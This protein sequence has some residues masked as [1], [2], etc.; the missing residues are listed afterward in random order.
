MA[1]TDS[2]NL[3]DDVELARGTNPTNPDTDNDGLLDGN[4]VWSQTW[5]I[6]NSPKIVDRSTISSSISL[7]SFTSSTLK[8]I[9]GLTL[10]LGIAHTYIGD[11]Y[12]TISHGGK[13]A[14]LWNRQGGSADYIY[15][16]YDLL[17]MGFT[18][19][20]LV[21]T[22]AWTL[23]IED[24]AGGDEGRLEYFDLQVTGGSNPLV[25]DTDGDG[26]WDGEEVNLGA[27]GWITNLSL[28][29]I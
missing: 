11:L 21:S 10:Y 4:E 25:R 2:D 17:K 13:S 20:D 26:I 14:I 29:H 16:S 18:V 6:D 7:P 5:S 27:D 1:D 22:S 9:T 28:I 3:R 23:V 15:K 24:R 12:I 19:Q 8:P